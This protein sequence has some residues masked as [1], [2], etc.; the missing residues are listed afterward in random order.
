LPVLSVVPMWTGRHRQM[1][2]IIYY[3]RSSVAAG[4]WKMVK[5]NVQKAPLIGLTP[6][7]LVA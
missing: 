1:W 5:R 3:E 2:T 7:N 6:S 4:K